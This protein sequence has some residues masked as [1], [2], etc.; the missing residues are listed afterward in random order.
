MNRSVLVLALLIA[1]PFGASAQV[2][3]TDKPTPLRPVDAQQ[4]LPS[5]KFKGRVQLSGQFLVTRELSDKTTYQLRIALHPDVA[6]AAVLPRLGQ[7]DQVKELRI[8]NPENAAAMLLDSVT[9]AKLLSGELPNATFNA[10]ATFQKYEIAAACD[11]RFYF[12]ELV[13]VSKKQ[14]FVAG[15]SQ[16]ISPGCG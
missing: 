4:Q 8:S 14:M 13:A 5:A 12:A 1:A 11:Q 6:S 2:F 9:S 7:R 16:T 10:T 15:G 3:V